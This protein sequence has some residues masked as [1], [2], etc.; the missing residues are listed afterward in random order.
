[1]LYELIE[2]LDATWSQPLCSGRQGGLGWISYESSYALP[3]W[4]SKHAPCDPAEGE[5]WC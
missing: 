3:D 4:T 1:M 2:G 5:A